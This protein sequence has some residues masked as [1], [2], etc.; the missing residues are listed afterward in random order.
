MKKRYIILIIILILIIGFGIYYVNDYSHSDSTALSYINGSENVSVTH[1]SNGLFIDGKG[2]DT[3]LIFYPGAKVEY[4]AYLPLMNQIAAQGVD[5]YLVQMPFNLAFFGQNSAD[6]II[7]NSNYS[8]Y[9]MSGHSL[10]GVA[11][12]GYASK[13]DVDGLVLLAAYPSEEIDKPTL[14]IYGSEDKVL[15]LKS[16]NDA[17]PL[18]KANF[19]EHIING[20]NHAQFGNYGLQKGDGNAGIN[21]TLQQNETTSEIINF[22]NKLF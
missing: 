6:D 13:H 15:N 19:T 17:K 9:I 18:I 4:S 16:Y 7:K 2:N 3:A 12:S 22:I 11:A 14:S 8:H 5:V 21:S 20:G 10:G 1:S